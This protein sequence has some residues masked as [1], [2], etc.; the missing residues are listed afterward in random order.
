M[1]RYEDK[2]KGVDRDRR[3]VIKD[4]RALEL[5]QK[6]WLVRGL[7]EDTVIGLVMIYKGIPMM[8]DI[9]GYCEI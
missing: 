6:Y 7:E 1:G 8:K 3:R 4:T 2:Y 5:V 9:L